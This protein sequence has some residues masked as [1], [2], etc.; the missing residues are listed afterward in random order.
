MVDKYP[1]DA[2][3]FVCV[4][5]KE[6]IMGLEKTVINSIKEDF[7][8]KDLPSP[9]VWFEH[10][11]LWADNLDNNEAD[12]V[13]DAIEKVVFTSHTGGVEITKFNPTERE[14]WTHWAFDF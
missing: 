13:K 1:V 10:G 7:E 4:E 5:E 3:M 11:T 14:P 12:V 6:Q 9:T 8:A 2:I